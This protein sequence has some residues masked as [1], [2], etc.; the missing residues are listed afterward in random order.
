VETFGNE[1][2]FV[3]IDGAITFAFE[4]KHPL[5]SNYVLV[6]GCTKVQVQLLSK[7]SN[8][9]FIASSQLGCLVATEVTSLE[10]EAARRA[11]VEQIANE[12]LRKS[13]RLED[14]LGLGL[15]GMSW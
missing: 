13:L 11:L 15:H 5:A 3:A 14:V 2:T 1:K 9:V 7:A 8:S 10:Q 6:E 12:T 4:V